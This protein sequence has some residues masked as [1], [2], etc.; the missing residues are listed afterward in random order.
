[1]RIISNG[2]TQGEKLYISILKFISKDQSYR[3]G[4]IDFD[5]CMS[6]YVYKFCIAQMF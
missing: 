6:T 3:N 2:V 4:A 1:M 5:T